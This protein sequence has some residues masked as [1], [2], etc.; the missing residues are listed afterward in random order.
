MSFIPILSNLVDFGLVVVNIITAISVT[1]SMIAMAW[2]VYRPLL[3]SAAMLLVA[4]SLGSL[5]YFAKKKKY[6]WIEEGYACE[7]MQK[8]A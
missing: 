5:S 1:V 8:F 2:I 4:I 6:E 3:G 7:D